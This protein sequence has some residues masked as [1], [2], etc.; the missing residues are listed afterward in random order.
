MKT[1]IADPW[2]ATDSF[3][4]SNNQRSES[5]EDSFVQDRSA[6]HKLSDHEEYLEKLYSRLKNLQ[7]GTTKK[8]LV[9]SLSSAK[10]DCIARLISSNRLLESEEAELASNPLIRHIAPHLQAIAASELVYLLKADVL[11]VTTESQREDNSEVSEHL[12]EH[13]DKGEDISKEN[14]Q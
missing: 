8:D 10:E 5:F 11:Q 2:C 14:T 13:Q 9:A 4:T 12:E 6:Q 1:V 7:G 3:A